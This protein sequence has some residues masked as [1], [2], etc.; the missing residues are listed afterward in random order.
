MLIFDYRSNRY[1]TVS[2]RIPWEASYRTNF[3][4][5]DEAGNWSV[6]NRIGAPLFPKE[7]ENAGQWV[8]GYYNAETGT[9]AAKLVGSKY[10]GVMDAESGARIVGFWYDATLPHEWK[11]GRRVCRV[12]RGKQEWKVDD[13]H[14]RVSD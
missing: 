5:R 6:V 14:Q 12:F 9:V 4:V 1:I 2:D 11:D 13:K 8:Y 3:S 10:W 7:D